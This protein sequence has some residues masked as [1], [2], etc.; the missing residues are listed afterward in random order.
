MPLSLLPTESLPR[1]HDLARGFALAR[2]AKRVKQSVCH[3]LFGPLHRMHWRVVSKLRRIKPP[4]PRVLRID[5]LGP[6]GR[7]A[8]VKPPDADL[9]R[10]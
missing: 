1:G 8:E 2:H 9:A 7:L 5:G 6:G 10:A 3:R 4:V